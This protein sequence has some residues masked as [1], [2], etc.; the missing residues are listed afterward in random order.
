[1]TSEFSKENDMMWKS[2]DEITELSLGRGAIFRV[3]A[4]YPY[5]EYVD[6]ML[7]VNIDSPCGMSVLVASGFKSGLIHVNPPAEA[8]GGNQSLSTEWLK[9]NWSHWINE[10]ELS[11]IKYIRRRVIRDPSA[12][13]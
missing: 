6:F 12:N 4:S 3:P 9:K 1:M 2:F 10:A 8:K 5:E 13:P 7:I 11:S